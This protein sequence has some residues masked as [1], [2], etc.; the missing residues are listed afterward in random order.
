L[1][2]TVDAVAARPNPELEPT[3]DFV[4]QILGVS[5]PCPTDRIAVV[6]RRSLNAAVQLCRRRFAEV[7]CLAMQARLCS[8]ERLD[9]LWVLNVPSETE[10]RGIV[11]NVGRV[12]RTGGQLVLGFE[13]PISAAHAARLLDVLREIGFTAARQL[14]DRAGGV[15]CLCCRRIGCVVAAPRARAA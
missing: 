10:L 4:A 3:A 15:S 9:A 7:L 6:G 2:S 13:R 8:A 5:Q 12:L 14:P 1:R 11:L